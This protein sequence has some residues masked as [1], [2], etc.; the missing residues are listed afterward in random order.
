MKT[1]SKSFIRKL[2]HVLVVSI[3]CS[4]VSVG[5]VVRGEVTTGLSAPFVES[6]RIGTVVQIPDYY[7]DKGGKSV[8]ATANVITP[9]GRVFAGSK[10][11][12]DEGGRYVVEYVVDSA[13][14]HTEDCIAVMGATDMFSVN[15]LASIGG[16]ADYKY[17]PAGSGFKGVAVNVNAGS[18]VTFNREIDME[19]FTKDEVFFEATVEP[20]V[21]GEADFKQ[22]VITLSDPSDS[23]TY[24]RIKISDGH[25][26]GGTPKH[27]IFVNGAANGQTAG[28]YNY[29]GGHVVWQE[30]DIYGTSAYSSFRAELAHDGYSDYSIKLYYDSSEKA[31]YIPRRGEMSLIVDFD[32]PVVFGGNAWSGFESGKAIMSVSFTEVEGNGGRVIFNQIAGISLQQDLIEDTVAPEI[33]IDLGK[34]EKAPNSLIGTQYKVF[35]CLVYDFFDS[36]VKVETK[37]VYENL[38]TGSKSDVLITNGT[39]KTDKLGKY[40]IKYTAIDYSGNKTE[41]EISFEC[42]AKA[43]KIVLTQ[44]PSDFTATVFDEVKVTDVSLI[45][46]YGGNGNLDITVKVVDC[47]GEEVEIVESSFIPKKLGEYRIL[48]TATDNY[49]ESATVAVKVNVTAQEK[50]MF[51]NGILMPNVLVADFEYTIPMVYAKACS[52]GEIIDCEIEYRVNGVKIDA[53]RKFKADGSVKDTKIECLALAKDGTVLDTTSKDVL[54]IDGKGG[55]DQTAYFCNYDGKMTVEE[56][57][58]SI[59]LIASADTY[60]EFANKLNAYTFSLGLNYLFEECNFESFNVTLS[61]VNDDSVSLT[62]KFEI[63]ENGVKITSPYGDQTEFP[64]SNGYFKFNFNSQSGIVTDANNLSVTFADKD[65]LGRPF[66]GFT[67]GIYVKFAFREV[68]AESKISLSLLNNQSLGFRSEFE[69]DI[70]DVKGPEIVVLGDLPV[71]A[72][73]GTEITV[74]SA[75]AYDV[76]SQSLAP[77]VQVQS[78]SGKVVVA[79]KLADRDFTLKLDEVGTYR[80]I[81]VAYDTATISG[82]TEGNRTRLGQIVTVYDSVAP[83][84]Q[85]E[86]SDMEKTVGDVITLPTVSATDDSKVAYYDVFLTLPT[87]EVRML[88]HGENGNETSYLDEKDDNY[89]P[90]FKVSKNQFKLEMKGKYVLTIMAYDDNY[91]L[92]MKTF[93]ITVK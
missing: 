80:I 29:D 55:K 88:L 85:V 2:C 14:V 63:S 40:T 30:K 74:Y 87:S 89:P 11:T 93:T 61:D 70:R 9:N 82:E 17:L 7:V 78:P 12:A 8:K 34:Q 13:V 43:E 26:D 81:Y 32:D 4:L 58:N 10:F 5:L 24:F 53:S 21:Q 27:V 47:D 75:I 50:T 38:F 54:V 71:R 84:M 33:T 65:D 1:N 42:I 64:S 79:Q 57:M 39:F 77:T 6:V 60:A 52:Q 16:I 67:D 68:F 76:L 69:E 59:D 48:Y 22:M 66:T 37:V 3:V 35:P 90:S 28:G 18:T 51:L 44:V 19:S 46:A 92:V 31:L 49:G 62:F 15:A 45:R 86:F 73:L 41:K 56:T 72:P 36:N 83:T 23:S 20:K 91:N 25:A